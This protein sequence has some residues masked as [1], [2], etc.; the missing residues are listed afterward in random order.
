MSGF[1]PVAE[2]RRTELRDRFR[3]LPACADERDVDLVLVAGDLFDSATPSELDLD[4][5]RETL[6]GL[7]DGGNR[8]VVVVPGNHDPCSG[9]GSPWHSMPAGVDVML[10]PRFEAPLEF[11]IRGLRVHV[12]GFA[13]D[14]DVEPDPVRSYRR[15]GH[16]L[17][18][19]VL[20]ASVAGNPEWTGG[21]GL[22]LTLEDLGH[23]DA[24]Y[25]ALGDHHAF[26]TSGF[27]GIP[28]CYP[29]SFAAVAIDEAGDRGCALA[30]VRPEA[31]PVVTLLPSGVA[32]LV[33]LGDVDAGDADGDLA[34]AERIGEC[35]RGRTGYPAVTITGQPAFAL[36]AERVR[37]ALEE[38]F[39]FAHVVDATRFIDSDHVARLAE[40][41]TVEGHVARLGRTRLAAAAS[42]EDRTVADRALR[43]ALRAMEVE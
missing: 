26:R 39:G 28:A 27:G 30:E 24:D 42:D 7:T 16:G 41:P 36:D 9:E 8:P 15:L 32:P 2:A 1:E 43:M 40:R 29:G 11:D 5:A 25:V 13:H 23:I 35:M 4:I 22:R 14:P 18:V 10:A 3:E 33:A 34:V 17:H 38:R 6:R 37:R 19:A 20:H 31:P 12:H 21:R